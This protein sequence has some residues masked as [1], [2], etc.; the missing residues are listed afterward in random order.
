MLVFTFL[1]ISFTN[2][3]LLQSLVLAVLLCCRHLC[4]P[5]TP[6]ECK[7]HGTQQVQVGPHYIQGGRCVEK[8]DETDNFHPHFA[9][10]IPNICFLS[11]SFPL[12]ALFL[13]LTQQ[14]HA[15]SI[16]PH[17]NPTH[18]F[19]HDSYLPAFFQLQYNNFAILSLSLSYASTQTLL[20]H[21][22]FMGQ[23]DHR[24]WEIF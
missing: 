8:L 20:C 17:H 9:Y 22:C 15:T 5:H 16:V 4:S 6:G 24:T 10:F 3:S 1:K 21:F 11:S 23:N 13:P 18:L 12:L 14:Q 2:L 19:P 7:T